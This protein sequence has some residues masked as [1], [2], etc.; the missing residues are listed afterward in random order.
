MAQRQS[1][2]NMVHVE[3]GS[4]LH[5]GLLSFGRRSPAN[6]SAAPTS[7]E[8]PSE[9]TANQ[10]EQQSSD[11]T[12]PQLA[13][14]FEPLREFGGVGVMVEQPRLRLEI[15]F[16][17]YDV[18]ECETDTALR[19]RLE[20][21]LNRWRI[22]TCSSDSTEKSAVRIRLLEAPP[23]HCGFGFG[24]QLGLTLACG[25]N[26][27]FERPEM[28]AAQL[29]RQVGRGLRSAVGTYGFVNGGLIVDRGKLPGESIAPLACHLNFPNDWRFVMASDSSASGV[30]G[31]QE[32]DAFKQLP[33]VPIAH[34]QAMFA[35]LHD[36][37]LPA[38]A[39]A[40]FDRFAKS[41]WRYG[42]L[43]GECFFAA[44]DGARFSPAAKHWIDF[45]RAAGFEGVGQ[46]SWGP[47]VYVVTPDD[48]SARELAQ[49]MRLS[50]YGENS[51]VWIAAAMSGG[52]KVTIVNA[53]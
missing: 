52:R 9:S 41:L 21:F 47:A 36:H 51:R 7:I 28:E 2:N 12:A 4:R 8:C 44:Q 38:A 16:H 17:E 19:L 32:T 40:D 15:G 34:S 35:E 10:V 6:H 31:Q 18:I 29:A 3:T 11:S 26:Q 37:L 46:T 23:S 48:A 30:S 20:E 22:S 14:S 53:S 5:F 33:P 39:A 27:L 45:A 25:L 43:A 49:Q 42:S 13:E 24:T 1:A 50:K